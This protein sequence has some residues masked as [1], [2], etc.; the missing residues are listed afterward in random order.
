MKKLI[1]ISLISVSS[2]FA[3]SCFK[4][5]EPS[6]KTNK[7]IY[8]Y[9]VEMSSYDSCLTRNVIEKQSKLISENNT[10]TKKQNKL[11]EENNKLSKKQIKTLE[12]LK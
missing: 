8:L 7:N 3:E 11:I 2:L 1:L 6:F 12:K 10:L 5:S 9:T 4:P